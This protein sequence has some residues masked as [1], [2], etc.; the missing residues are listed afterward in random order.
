MKTVLTIDLG[1]SSGRAIVCGL[2][3]GKLV[4]HEVHRF[5]NTPVKIGDRLHWDM[6]ALTTNIKLGIQKAAAEY[7]FD[8]IGIDTWGVDFGLLDA[9]GLLEWPVHYRDARTVG[10]LK[11]VS[12]AVSQEELYARTGI[13][14]MEINTLFQLYSLQQQR[15]ELLKRATDLLF[16][17][18]LLGWILTDHRTAEVSIASTSQLL[19]P[20]TKQWDSEL[21]ARLQLPSN[22]LRPVVDSGS[23]L[24]TLRPELC[25]ELSCKQVKVISVAGHDTACAVAAAPLV[26]DNALFLSS[27]TW[28]LLGKER[29]QP[30]LSQ[31]SAQYELTNETGYNDKIT[32]LCNISGTWLLQQCRKN[33]RDSGQNVSYDDLMNMALGSAPFAFF[34]D[35]CDDAFL[36]PDNMLDAIVAYCQATGQGTPDQKQALRAVYDSLAMKYRDTA[37]KIAA[38]T[39]TP[40]SCLHMVGGGIKDAFLCQQTA[41]ATGC[42][43]LAGPIEAT[44]IGNA[45]I[46]HIALGHIDNLAAARNIVRNSFEN[47][48]YE[49][50]NTALYSQQ[51]KSFTDILDR[52]KVK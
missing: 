32:Y 41:N 3:G 22:I 36:S 28:S 25:E 9:D 35:P 23:L 6:D 1:A 44:A 4:L 14:I 19:N 48:R 16:M 21:L 24:G 17:P 31:L 33:L 37:T 29:S 40:N 13:Q 43:V 42:P 51:Y 15:P 39:E 26:D 10:T 27:G 7:D 18:D 30:V 2:S 38:I 45:I 49:P 12:A 52:R 34:I 5:D 20:T 11:Q 47:T 50:R 8:S 46:Q